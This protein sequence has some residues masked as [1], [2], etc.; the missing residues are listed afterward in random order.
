MPTL[1]LRLHRQVFSLL[2][3]L[4]IC[5]VNYQQHVLGNSTECAILL[6]GFASVIWVF[7]TPVTRQPVLQIQKLCLI[8]S[9]T[10]INA[11]LISDTDS[12]RGMLAAVRRELL[13]LL[14]GDRAMIA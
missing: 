10:C 5:G 4:A 2:L 9:T 1:L 11:K 13:D 3:R 14:K 12:M 6:A 7:V 8:G